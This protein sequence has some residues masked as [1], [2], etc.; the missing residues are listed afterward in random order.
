MLNEQQNREK[1]VAAAISVGSNT[2]L[3]VGKL[4]AGIAIGSVS[5]I[6]EAIHSAVDLLAAVIAWFAVRASGQ[7]AD[8]EHP[9]GHGKY[10]NLSG[11]VEGALIFVA[12]I[13][14]VYEA[15]HKLR[16]GGGVEEP[17]WGMLI[18]GIS[19]T[20]NLAV[21]AN[22]MRVGK[23]TDS[24]ALIA[25]AMHLRTDVW[26]SVGVLAG[27]VVIWGGKYM[28]PGVNLAWVDPV[29]AIAVAL[30]IIHAAYELTTQA[31]RGLLDE[32]LPEDEIDFIRKTALERGD[33]RSLHDLKTR[34]AGPE[35]IIDAHVA[36][37]WNLTVL[38]GH[39]RGKAFKRT[40]LDHWEH[41][42]VNI[43]VDACDGA[44]GAPCKSG[45]LLSESEREARHGAWKGKHPEG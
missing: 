19:A 23:K 4:V 24:L 37:D 13:W 9:Y 41:C 3:V 26:T 31:T 39:N 27:L 7:P 38:D 33:I 17:G 1:S 45:C 10:E 34:K 16:V 29:C 20:A 8:K 5:V 18:M 42:N 11:A 30:L 40:L 32:A 36:V 2:L 44:C 15:I 28:F 35:R 14:I 43:H 12:A 6:S 21:S 22:L 25:D